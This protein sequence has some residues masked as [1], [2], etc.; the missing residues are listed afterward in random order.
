MNTTGNISVEHLLNE[1]GRLQEELDFANES[2]DDK[3]DKL[4]EA[5]FGVIDLAKALGEAR[6]RIELLEE[7][8]RNSEERQASQ[9]ETRKNSDSNHLLS[10]R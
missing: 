4:E 5:G 8:L 3:L 2:V 7:Q 10:E 6:K 1:I 9:S